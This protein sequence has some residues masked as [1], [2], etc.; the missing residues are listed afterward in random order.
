LTATLPLDLAASIE[1]LVANLAAGRFD[2]AVAAGR[3]PRLSSA[4]LERG[5]GEYGRTLV[6]LPAG[7]QEFAWRYGV[8]AGPTS[9]IDVDLW[10]EEEGRSDLTLQLNAWRNG[11]EWVLDITDLRVL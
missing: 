10:T 8:A 9:A 3:S 1:R 2:E 11:G 7:W 6:P 5:I 4:D